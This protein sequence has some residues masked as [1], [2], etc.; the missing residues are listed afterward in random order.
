MSDKPRLVEVLPSEAQ[1]IKDDGLGGPHLHELHG[2]YWADADEL[3]AWRATHT[4][5]GE[6]R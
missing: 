3:R 1:Q 5:D 6:Q 2:I 4:S